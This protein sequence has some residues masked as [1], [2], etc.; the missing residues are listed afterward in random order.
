M[1]QEHFIQTIKGGL[2]FR[3][4]DGDNEDAKSDLKLNV[5]ESKPSTYIPDIL[6][7][8]TPQPMELSNGSGGCDF[9]IGN[10]GD[11]K[12]D[13]SPQYAAAHTNICDSVS[14]DSYR[15]LSP[16]NVSDLMV[17][18]PLTDEGQHSSLTA[19]LSLYASDVKAALQGSS[20]IHSCDATNGIKNVETLKG[21]FRE[22]K[23]ICPIS[24]LSTQMA[25]SPTSQEKLCRGLN[26][27]DSCD[28]DETFHC[29]EKLFVEEQSERKNSLGEEDVKT[30][31]KLCTSSK[32]ASESTSAQKA[33]T[34]SKWQ[35]LDTKNL[36]LDLMKELQV[37]SSIVEETSHSEV[38]QAT[39]SK[40]NADEEMNETKSYEVNKKKKIRLADED[41][42]TL[43]HV[44][45]DPQH[46]T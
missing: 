34:F 46:I 37:M 27:G 7:T 10:D 2:F 18:G 29:R 33:I 3:G 14:Q 42:G 20:D 32:F 19:S 28:N 31:P 30:I 13:I 8:D 24:L 4:H 22:G 25:T 21:C 36:A 9:G 35:M 41:G 5:A 17:N 1:I 15:S 38:G 40:Y 26:A 45:E 43:C 16:N 12:K 6:T 23:D 11:T 44:R 39:S